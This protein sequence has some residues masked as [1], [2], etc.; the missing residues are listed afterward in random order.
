MET[1]KAQLELKARTVG[2]IVGKLGLLASG[3]GESDLSAGP[4][5]AA[6]LAKEANFY[7]LSANV[8]D[9]NG[10][11]PFHSHMLVDVG[12]VRV[13]LFG[14]TS[15]LTGSAPGQQGLAQSE[16]IAV[17]REEIAFLRPKC[18]VLVCLSHMGLAADQELARQT[19]GIDVI[20]GGH[21]REMTTEPIVAGST[22]VVQAFSQGKYVGRLDLDMPRVPGVPPT[23]HF[24][25]SGQAPPADPKLSRFTAAFVALDKKMGEDAAIVA[26]IKSYNE[27][28]AKLVVSAKP[29][30]GAPPVPGSTTPTQQPLGPPPPAGTFT[31][32]GVPLCASCHVEQSKFW[33]GTVHARAIDILKKK[34]RVNDQECIGCHTTGFR[35]PGGFDIPARMAGFENVQCEACHGPGLDHG[36]GSMA[37]RGSAE[38]TCRRCHDKSNSPDFDYAAML[39]IMSCPKMQRAPK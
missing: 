39:P 16:P 13:G 10:K 6:S 36:K 14:I 8:L 25:R 27:A 29:P 32:W 1:E 35:E 34:N 33:E 4:E 20:V 38:A 37:K 18:E 15:T 31:Y 30:A 19:A 24:V 11:K 9:K 23:W 12:G 3:L 2:K 17:A 21:S 28:V 26:D 7:W 5:F 22:L